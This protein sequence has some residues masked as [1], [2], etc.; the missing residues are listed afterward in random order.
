MRNKYPAILNKPR[1]N[2]DAQ[3]GAGSTA[4]LS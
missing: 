3:V 2:L 4:V 1:S